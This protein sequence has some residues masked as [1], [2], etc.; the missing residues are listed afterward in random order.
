MHNKLLCFKSFLNFESIDVK[1]FFLI[2][3][4]W[5]HIKSTNIEIGRQDFLAI[6]GM[7]FVFLHE[8]I[9]GVI[10]SLQMLYGGSSVDSTF[11]TTDNE[12]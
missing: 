2:W 6:K 7:V 1:I 5:L 4:S 11:K 8:T 3:H 10:M 9:L 12:N